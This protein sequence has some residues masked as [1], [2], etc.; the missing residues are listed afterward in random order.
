M[1]AFPRQ[2]ATTVPVAGIATEGVFQDQMAES[3]LYV[4]EISQLGPS[5]Y[6]EIDPYPGKWAVGR[7]RERS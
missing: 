4:T 7:R 1:I 5:E 6:A 3:G 2:P